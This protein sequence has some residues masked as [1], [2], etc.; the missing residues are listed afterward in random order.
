MKDVLAWTQTYGDKRML[1][2]KLLEHDI[3]GNR[4]RSGCQYLLFSFHNC[5]RSVYDKCAEVLRRVYTPEKL[6]L[7]CFDNCSYLNCYRQ[8]VVRAKQLGCD[9]ILQIQDDQHGVNSADNTAQLE[10]IDEVVSTYKTTPRM[11]FLHLF[12]KEG[13]PQASLRPL[14]TIKTANVEFYQYDS[15]DFQKCKLWSW[16]DGTY[17]ISV[18]L[19]EL[20]LRTPGLPSDVWRLEIALKSIFDNHQFYRWGTDKVMFG[21]SNLF[22]R[23]VNTR[24]SQ[25]ENLSRFF[26]ESDGWKE[27]CQLLADAA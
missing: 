14:D 15:R 24:I 4:M 26:G 7:V 27:V 6:L 17:I 16:N 11:E 20:L 8:V 22:G 19:M 2:L 10:D 9:S 1:N 13:K 5:P 23:N 3:V 18:R 25:Q 12:G 21:A